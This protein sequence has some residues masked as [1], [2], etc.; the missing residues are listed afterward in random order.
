MTYTKRIGKWG[1]LT[2]PDSEQGKWHL[3][4]SA[5]YIFDS[6][7]DAYKSALKMTTSG[8]YLYRPVQVTISAEIP[9]DS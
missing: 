4:I 6:E 5:R 7:V 8:E 2:K 9:E 3:V 1:L